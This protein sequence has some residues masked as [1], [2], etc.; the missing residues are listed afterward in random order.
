MNWKSTPS[1]IEIAATSIAAACLGGAVGF[2]VARIA[3]F[4]AGL[5]EASVA[6]LLA[7]LVGWAM[8]GR[9]DSRRGLP[10]LVPVAPSEG[11]VT[12]KDVLLLDQP[13]DDEALLLDDPLPV[14]RDDM[15]VVRL[16]AAH[17]LGAEASAPL[18]G[19][20]EM[21][22][23]IEK[24]LGQPRGSV[25]IAMPEHGAGR[26]AAEDASAA[27]HVALADIRRSLRQA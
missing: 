17:P 25:A 13:V 15:R 7:V 3:P 6:G 26:A 14:L 27:L 2:A 22:E 11:N 20:G 12:D 1:R 19:P 16:F 18:A 8:I 24:F 23:R 10:L 9:V 4:G 21:I 5:I